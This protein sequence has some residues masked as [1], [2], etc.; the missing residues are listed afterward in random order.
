MFN[1]LKSAFSNTSGSSD[2]EALVEELAGQTG[3]AYPFNLTN[4]TAG[5]RFL[6]ADPQT[7]RTIVMAMLAWLQNHPLKSYPQN[8]LDQK[9]WQVGWQM[10]EALLEMLKRKIPFEEPDVIAMLNW[11]AGQS[12]GS[13]YAYLGGVPQ[14]IK[15]VGDYLKNNPVSDDL[16][17]AIERLIQSIEA[18]RMSVENRRW[19]LR[20]KDLRGDTDVTLPLFAGDVWA[21]N[22]ISE[23]RT[24]DPRI[25]TAWAELLLH[26]LRAT[27]SAPSSKWLK[28]TEKY[29]D[30]IG[31]RTFFNSLLRWLPLVDGPRTTP[32]HPREHLQTLLP[33]NADI[34]KGLVWLCSKSEKPEIARALTS[35]AISAYKKVPGSGPRAGKVGN[36]CFWTLGNMPGK[37]GVAQLSILKIKIKTKFIWVQ[38]IF[39]WNRM[40]NI[41]VS[42]PRATAAKSGKRICLSPLK[43]TKHWPLF[44]RKRFFWLTTEKSQIRRSPGKLRDRVLS[45]E[46]SRPQR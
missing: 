34:L 2:A 16:S 14:M 20:L 28:G 36:A 29:L 41:F 37:E 31:N 21:D 10:R 40:I 43:G 13:L 45:Q 30:T 27:G 19:V 39:S 4:L 22:A 24:L 9:A 26:C 5:N 8:P 44:C 46:P 23:L 11:S 12:R 42:S 17:Q 7:Q 3:R 33:V 35:L 38:A 6:R 15:V 18:E 32:A 25:Q 1:F